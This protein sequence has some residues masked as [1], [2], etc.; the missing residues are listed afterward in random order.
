MLSIHPSRMSLASPDTPLY[1]YLLAHQPPAHEA[2]RRLRLAT[3]GIEG[4][5]M[6]IG[7]DQGHLM[8]LLVK[9]IGARRI[10]E[11]GTF[12][13]DSALALAPGGRLITC[14]INEDWAAVGQPFWADAGAQGKNDLRIGPALKSLR[15]LEAEAGAGQHFDH[16][17]LVFIDADKPNYP[18]YHEAA[19]RQLRPGGLVV[20][21]N[22]LYLG[23]VIDPDNR[24]RKW[25]RSVN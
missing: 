23:R 5:G 15:Q 17:D 8:A 25:W 11:L 12:T 4:A 3:Q 20:L 24:A 6:Q 21:D 7:L 16:F 19:L 9:L 22:M 13:G 2:L 14:D 10:I 1:Q 18:A